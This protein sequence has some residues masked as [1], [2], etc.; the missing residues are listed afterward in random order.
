MRTVQCQ[1]CGRKV[2]RLRLC[3]GCRLRVCEGCYL[4]SACTGGERMLWTNTHEMKAVLARKVET[5]RLAAIMVATRA[6]G[7][8]HAKDPLSSSTELGA[9][10]EPFHGLVEEVQEVIHEV[11]GV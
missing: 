11:R 1:D 2:V 6:D 8:C 4:G 9:I 5:E 10:P 3:E 7:R